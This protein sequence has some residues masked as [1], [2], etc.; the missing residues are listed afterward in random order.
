MLYFLVIETTNPLIIEMVAN[1]VM[2]DAQMGF[3]KFNCER[4]IFP[5]V[6][7]HDSRC[8]DQYDT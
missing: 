2:K 6:Y 5:G 3:A 7:V 8:S 4:V 1:S